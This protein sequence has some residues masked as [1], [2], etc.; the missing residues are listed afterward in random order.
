MWP[1]GVVFVAVVL[2]DHASF[3]KCP[4]LLSVKTLISEASMK[5]FYEPILP[6]T[7]GINVDRLDLILFKPRLDRL[8]DELT[9]V[10]T[11]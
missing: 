11:P 2:D 9:A 1:E 6:R 7:T 8:S 3:G 10:I 4:K 5:A